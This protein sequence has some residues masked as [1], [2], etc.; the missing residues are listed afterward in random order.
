MS[1]DSMLRKGNG[2]AIVAQGVNHTFGVGETSTQVLFDNHLTI[3][4]GEIVIMTGPSGSGKT[5]LLTLI[6]AI[7][8][9]QE[10]SLA[11]LGRELLGMSAAEQ[12]RLRQGIGFIF[13]Q[14]NLFS[15]LSALENTRMALEL[16][17]LS[18]RAMDERA[19]RIL[20]RLGLAERLEY[21]PPKLSGGQRQRVAIARALVNRPRLVLADEPTAALDA[22]SGE[23]VMQLFRELASGPERTT[24]LVVTHDKRLIDSASRIVNMVQGRIISNVVTG[25]SIRIAEALTKCEPFRTMSETS[26]ARIADRMRAETHPAET[27]IIRQGDA[28]D[29]FYVVDD[30]VV[31]VTIDGAARRELGPGDFFGEVALLTDSPR[32]ATV[33][34]KTAV[35]LFALSKAEFLEVIATEESLAQRLRRVYMDRQ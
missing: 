12:V 33:K 14:H 28:G 17:G 6:G 11:V 21:K 22:A 19:A 13:Q 31:E 5:T 18:A 26:L 10:G 1:A 2:P 16:S 27:V 29:R 9:V 24:I 35:R 3:D 4:P 32:T 23:T 30:G 20:E 34:A 25:E 7:R 15:S 8:Q